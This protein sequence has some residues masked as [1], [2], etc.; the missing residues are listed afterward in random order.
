MSYIFAFAIGYD[1]ILSHQNINQIDI[2]E[3]FLEL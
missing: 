1:F 3:K 2:Q